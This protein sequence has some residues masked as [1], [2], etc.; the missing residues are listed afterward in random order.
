M[1]GTPTLTIA[2][3]TGTFSVAQTARNG[4]GDCVTYN[5]SSVAYISAKISTEQW[6]LNTARELRRPM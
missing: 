6:T 2:G 1:T 5:S 3:G 4:R